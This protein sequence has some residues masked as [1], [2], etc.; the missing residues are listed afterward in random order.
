[1]EKVQIISDKISFQF[2]VLILFKQNNIWRLISSLPSKN[3]FVTIVVQN[4]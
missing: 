4:F 2:S 3:K 1:M